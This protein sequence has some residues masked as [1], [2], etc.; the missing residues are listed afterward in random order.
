VSDVNGR[1]VR[2][3]VVRI[4][5]SG[6]C[7]SELHE[8]GQRWDVSG[9]AVPEGMCGYA[10]NSISPFVTALRFGGRPWWKDES[11]I[12][13]CCPDADNPVVFRLTAME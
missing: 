11:V 12:T 8:I 5:G 13:V 9:S 4:L 10:Y 2:I 7:S 3:E 6:K 1:R